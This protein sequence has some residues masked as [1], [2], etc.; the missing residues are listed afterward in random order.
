MDINTTESV[1]I[2][3]EGFNYDCTKF[4]HNLHTIQFDDNFNQKLRNIK[5]PSCT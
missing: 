4:T 3:N 1:F 5:F 2:F